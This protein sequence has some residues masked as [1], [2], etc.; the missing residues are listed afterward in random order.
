MNILIKNCRFVPQLTEGN[1]AQGDVLVA[2][3]K[4]QAVGQAPGAPDAQIID[5]GGKT[6]IPGIIDL[7]S[8][9][10]GVHDINRKPGA[11][12]FETYEFAKYLMTIGVTTVRDCGN[13]HYLPASGVRDAI[14][15]GIID[16]PRILSSGMTLSPTV[17]GNQNYTSSIREVDGPT[18][19]RKAA[20]DT[21]KNGADFVKFMGSGAM[22][23]AGSDPG[24]RLFEDD[25][26]KE[27]VNIANT[28]SSHVAVH[29]H[30]A[31]AIYHCALCGVR[32]IEHGSFIDQRAIDLLKGRKDMGVNPTLAIVCTLANREQDDP[33]YSYVTKM[34]QGL[35][36]DIIRCLK[37][38][39]AQG[40]FMGWG[41]DIS[42]EVY[43]EEPGIEFRMRK[44]VLG[45]SDMD[46]LRQA[47][48]NSAI[49]GQ[50]DDVTGSVTVGK[51]AD[52]LVVDGKPDEDI[53]CMYRVPQ[54]VVCGGKLVR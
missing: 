43:R 3:G 30:G 36:P 21:F 22:L 25:E 52:L 17:A 40:V 50:I 33:T 35:M 2:D 7:H 20:R 5:A 46:I 32:T 37:D 26:M 49:L 29:A 34:M 4:I 16:G 8:H 11:S 45:F 28:Y 48:I 39:Y 27:L 12:I 47:T 15:K 54:H 53:T 38:A 41:T 23:G 42:L 44:E 13:D 10:A 51:C 24:M 9:L 19:M 1:L 14:K 31:D 18:E 6:V